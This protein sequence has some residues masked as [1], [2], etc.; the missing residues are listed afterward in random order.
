MLEWR[1][2]G[3]CQCCCVSPKDHITLGEGRGIDAS[4]PENGRILAVHNAK[5]PEQV[6]KFLK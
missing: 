2:T 3:I 6:R 1:V 5:T 4:F